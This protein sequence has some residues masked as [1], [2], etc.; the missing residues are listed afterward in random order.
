[1]KIND[2]VHWRW[3]DE[4]YEADSAGVFRYARTINYKPE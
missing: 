2:E 1:L 4:E 3:P